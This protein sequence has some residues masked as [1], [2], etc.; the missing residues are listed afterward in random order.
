MS[1]HEN[2]VGPS[3]GSSVSARSLPRSVRQF[4]GSSGTEHFADHP[5]TMDRCDGRLHERTDSNM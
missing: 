4:I 2:G 1:V 5:E 3:T